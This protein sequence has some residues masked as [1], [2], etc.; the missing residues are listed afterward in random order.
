[1]K[2]RDQNKKRLCAA[3]GLLVA[4]ALW[5]VAVRVLDVRSIG[6]CG[7]TV[8]FATLNQFI[9]TLTGVHMMLY[10]VTDW[11]G[12]IP[13]GTAMGF[14]VLGLVQWIRRK[15][16]S[17]VDRS[18]FVLG[19]FYLVVIALFVL[20]EVMVINYRPVLI[21]GVLEAS[22]PS[23]TT[24]L[25]TCVMPTAAMQL[26]DRIR[27]ATVRRCVTLVIALFVAFMMIGRLLSGV[28]WVTDIIGGALLSAGLVTLYSFVSKEQR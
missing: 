1:M 6:P 11:L 12:L 14:A 8:G 24:L 10:T 5:T 13:I 18:L 4:F 26:C 9:H 17:R 27:N 22:Y 25:V 23:S 7:S 2:N 15:K 3:A 16:I 28:H 19:G 21:D 20:F